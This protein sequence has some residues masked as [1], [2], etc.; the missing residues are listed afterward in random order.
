MQRFKN[1]LVVVDDPERDRFVVKRAASMA[2]ANS[3]ALTIATITERLS[4]QI[5]EKL[6][7]SLKLDFELLVRKEKLE[8]L[9]KIKSRYCKKIPTI[10]KPQN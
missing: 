6:K 1:I 3:G 8:M 4:D 5:K 9:A 2:E 7:T 10:T